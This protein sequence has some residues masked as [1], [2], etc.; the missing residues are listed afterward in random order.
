M[1]CTEGQH[2]NK[3]EDAAKASSDA[4]NAISLAAHGLLTSLS[5]SSKPHPEGSSSSIL[6]KVRLSELCEKQT[7]LCDRIS[8]ENEKLSGAHASVRLD[9]MTSQTQAYLEKLKS[10][11]SEMSHLS[12]RST[13]MRERALRLQEA[14]Q[15]Q[16]LEREQE[17]QTQLEKEELLVAR[18]ET[19]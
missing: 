10:L 11:K 19:E 6:A 4:T 8:L 12:E 14:K 17:R 16:A 3:I 1:D 5:S 18:H 7:E 9:E 2:Q 13:Q 15:R